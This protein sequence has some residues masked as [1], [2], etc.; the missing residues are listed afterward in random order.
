MCSDML[1]R[2]H[3]VSEIVGMV[4]RSFGH[5]LDIL[6]SLSALEFLRNG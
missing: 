6:S 2:W 4:G 5:A 1:A 3:Q